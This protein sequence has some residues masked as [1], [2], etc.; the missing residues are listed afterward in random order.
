MNSPHIT[1]ALLTCWVSALRLSCRF[2]L[3]RTEEGSLIIV[4]LLMV[5][6]AMY[7]VQSINTAHMS[8]LFTQ[9]FTPTL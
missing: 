8:A 7:T 6:L 2:L 4:G 5:A 9:L 3:A 1:G